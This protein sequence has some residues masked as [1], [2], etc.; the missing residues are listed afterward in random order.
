MD[1]ENFIAAYDT[2]CN[3]GAQCTAALVALNADDDCITAL[4]NDDTIS[5]CSGS[6]ADLVNAALNTCP[7]VSDDIIIY[8]YSCELTNFML[9]K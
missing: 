1:I 8:S 9:L 7:N 6:C 5:S 3:S 2:A 4:D